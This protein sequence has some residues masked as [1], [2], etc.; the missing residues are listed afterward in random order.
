MSKVA[1]TKIS[2]LIR[3]IVLYTHS[4]KKALKHGR[5]ITRYI[6]AKLIL[7]VSTG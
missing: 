2:I 4:K 6:M 1:L 5:V 7:R 3:S